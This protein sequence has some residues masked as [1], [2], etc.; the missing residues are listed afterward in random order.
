MQEFDS[1]RDAE[2]FCEEKCREGRD[3]EIVAAQAERH[4]TTI[5]TGKTVERYADRLFS[6]GSDLH[7]F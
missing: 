7:L 2:R 1:R 5:D 3:A 6:R 4:E